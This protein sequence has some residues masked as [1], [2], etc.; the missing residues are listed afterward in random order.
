[1]WVPRWLGE[2][3]SRLYVKFGREPFGL[4]EVQ[5]TLNVSYEKSR[6]VVHHLHKRGLILVFERRRPRIYRLL[7]PENF[8]LIASGKVQRVEVAQ[9]RYV[10]LIYDCFRSVDRLVDLVSFVVYGSVGRGEASS[11][12]DL[13]LLV[14][15]DDF[16]GSLGER[17]ELL[18][19]RVRRDVK[20]ELEFLRRNGYYTPLSFYP[21]RREEARRTPLL[22]LDMVEDAVVVYDEEGFFEKLIEALRERLAELGAVRVRGRRGLYWDLK[23]DY[24]PLEVIHL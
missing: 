18:V 12:S 23:P 20:E 22:M 10:Q 2:A 11:T 17:V 6:V 21:L 14:I 8:I 9:E 5:E 7:S 3:Y 4:R 13:D 16:E 24:R 15:S 19:G 1:M